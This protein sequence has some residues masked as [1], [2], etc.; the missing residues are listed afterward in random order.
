M[1]LIIRN[2]NLPDGRI[3]IDIGIKDG[4]IV[5]LES[6]LSAKSQEEINASGYL[7]SPPFVDAHFHMDATLSLG[8]PRL[9]QSGTLLEGIALWG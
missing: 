8:L 2:A 1:D 4:K 7:V 6:S 3:G 5:A 9:N